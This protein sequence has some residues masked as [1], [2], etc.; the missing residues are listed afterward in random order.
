V[1]TYCAYA[2]PTSATAKTVRAAPSA[3][4]FVFSILFFTLICIGFGLVRGFADTFVKRFG[5]TVSGVF[6]V[7]V[8]W[9]W[10]Q[11]A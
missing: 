7:V 9:F 1:P 8:F 5:E 11:Y 6:R 4:I 2:T 3:R 10:G